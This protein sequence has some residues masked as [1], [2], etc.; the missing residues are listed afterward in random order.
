MKGKETYAVLGLSLFGRRA[1]VGLAEAGMSVIAVDSNGGKVQK[2]AHK[3]NDAVRADVMDWEALEHVGVFDVDTAVIGL[4]NAFEA[5]VLLTNH[6]R[7]ET[8]VKRII[9]QAD[10]EEKAEVLRLI[11]AD[12]VIF[13]AQDSADHLVRRL[14]MPGLVE[15][16]SLSPDAAIIEVVVPESFVGKTMVELM[17]RSKHK[18]NVVGVKRGGADE[19]PGR[20]VVAP[21]AHT[22]FR[23]GDS[24]LLVGRIE[25]LDRF[26]SLK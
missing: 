6:L 2:I 3:V 4:R 8:R 22:R 13:P 10:S 18:V 11:G 19:G 21:P 15:H 14:A 23:E 26:A 5:A 7:K 1:A 24:L 12:Q 16:V 17:V 25:D 9:V 20:M